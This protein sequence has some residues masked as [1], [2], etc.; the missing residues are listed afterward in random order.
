MIIPWKKI[1]S[2]KCLERIVFLA[3]FLVVLNADIIDDAVN[4][5]MA[6]N[7]VRGAA[8]TFYDGSDPNNI[9]S[10]QRGY[11]KVS[12]SD[13][14]ESVTADS[15]FQLASVSKP[16]TASAVAK[17]LDLGVITSIDQDI[18]TVIP[19]TWSRSACR[20]PIFRFAPITWRM[21][22]T[23]RSSM[24]SNIPLVISPETGEWVVASYGP[25]NF[26][27]G[28][29][30]KT[31]GNPTCPL[32]DVR[33]FYHTILTD[34]SDAQTSVGGGEIDWYGEMQRFGRGSWK[35]TIR[36]GGR[37][38]YSNYAFGYISALVEFALLSNSTVQTKSFEEFCQ[39]YI[40]QV[41]QMNNTSWFRENIMSATHTVGTQYNTRK[42]TYTDVGHNC[43]IDYASG[44]LYTSVNDISKFLHVMMSKGAPSLWSEAVGNQVLS[45]MDGRRYC[46]RRLGWKTGFAWILLS[47]TKKSTLYFKNDAMEAYDWTN[48]GYHNGRSFGVSTV[49][50]VLPSSNTYIA[51]LSNTE[52]V[53][54]DDLAMTVIEAALKTKN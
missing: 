50:I 31:Y 10:L 27:F 51:V 3:P 24:A 7:N 39:K 29:R 6:D 46:R 48:G 8:V 38:L 22:L 5:W 28:G 41:L 52:R 20:N 53:D 44:Q 25:A 30:G 36:P 2:S 17:L 21:L 54:V 4:T 16:F 40:F 14:A 11:G 23:H 45:C 15:V 13:T 43:Y 47:N 37:A 42:K 1:L 49:M 35:R 34:D 19:N 9:I 26:T 12:A 18:C 32:T 33:N